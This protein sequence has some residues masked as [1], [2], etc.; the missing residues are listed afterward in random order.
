MKL[1]KIWK[2]YTMNTGRKSSNQLH[3][4]EQ[5]FKPFQSGIHFSNDRYSFTAN[6]DKKPKFLLEF[7]VPNVMLMQHN[8]DFSD[9]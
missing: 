4:I 9:A 3:S 2:I 6:S 5:L 7:T 8:H 1:E